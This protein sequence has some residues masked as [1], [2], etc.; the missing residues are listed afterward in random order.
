MTV[1][2]IKMNDKYKQG[3]INIFNYYIETTTSAYREQT[4]NDDFFTNFC[5]SS[6]T[7]CSFAVEN[8]EGD[9]VGFC[10]LEKYIPLNT[11]SKAA[12]IMYFIHPEHT[13]K[14]IGTLALR[15]L[16]IEAKKRNITR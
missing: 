15:R 1:N 11:F 14:G 10:L 2:F 8:D 3:V 4:V 9:L 6:D 5:E 16:E 7:S 12:E 13:G